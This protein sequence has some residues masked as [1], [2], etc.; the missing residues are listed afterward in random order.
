M[1]C[2]IKCG[3][4]ISVNSKHIAYKYFIFVYYYNDNFIHRPII[5]AH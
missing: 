5:I 1:L 4:I 3:I 2:F